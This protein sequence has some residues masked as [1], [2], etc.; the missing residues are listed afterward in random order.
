MLT[1]TVVNYYLHCKRQCWLFYNRLNME[2]NSEDVHIGRVLH[3]LKLGDSQEASIENIR[4]DKITP[5]YVVEMKKS[6][7]DVEAAKAQLMFY[8]LKLDGKGI[9]RKGKLECVEKNKQDKK[10]HI[11]E[12]TEENKQKFEALCREI[13]VFLSSP[14]PPF[15]VDEKKC[16][17]CAYYE[18]CFV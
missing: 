2:D 12:L 11:I 16:K 9:V 5:E 14:M 18:Y 7:A 4:L 1:G 8:L 15:A 3:E 10:V 17:K 13:E 6:D